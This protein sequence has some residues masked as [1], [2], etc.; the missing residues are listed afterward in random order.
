MFP[1]TLEP[2]EFPTFNPTVRGD[3]W[4]LRGT[5]YYDRNANG[6]RDTV[7]TSDMGRDVE[8]NFGL[9]GVT[10]ELHECD[11]D[12]KKAFIQEEEGSDSGYGRT[13][14]AS[15]ISNGYDVVM[16]PDLAPR[17]EGGGR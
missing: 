16:R 4:V 17:N 9:G 15:T 10:V 7:D 3:P 1:S 11:P 2:T 8:H 14:F 13:S 6:I 12:T 5:I